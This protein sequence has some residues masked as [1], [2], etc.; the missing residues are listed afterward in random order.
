MKQINWNTKRSWNKSFDLL[1][2]LAVL[3]LSDVIEFDSL[4][5]LF[6]FIRYE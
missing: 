5:K 4:S 6:V 2:K 3:R 1:L